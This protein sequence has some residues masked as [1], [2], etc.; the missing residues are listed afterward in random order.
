MV[1]DFEMKL[2]VLI[3]LETMWLRDVICVVSLVVVCLVVVCLEEVEVV[4]LE[5]VEVVVV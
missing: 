1:V 3:L 2:E 5:E 4:C